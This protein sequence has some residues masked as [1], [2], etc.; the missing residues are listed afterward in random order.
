MWTEALRQRRRGRGSCRWL[1]G[2]ATG[3]LAQPPF[4]HYWA[5]DYEASVHVV[6]PKIETAARA[7]LR[8]L[9]EGIYRVQVAKD[10]GQYPGLYV[11]LQELQKL[12]LD[13]SWAISCAGCSS[14]P[15]E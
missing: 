3:Q 2:S 8:E 11:L 15:S 10:P 13:G 9:D 1:A 14:G 6:V 7:L 5:G 12:S 4:R